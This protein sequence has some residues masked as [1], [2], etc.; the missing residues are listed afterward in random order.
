[1]KKTIF[2]FALVSG[3]LMFASCSSHYDEID[4]VVDQSVILTKSANGTSTSIDVIYDVDV[5]Y[6][7]N[8]YGYQAKIRNST[9]YNHCS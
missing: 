7:K 1:M 5:N 8:I 4:E 6:L 9:Q 2:F 3:I